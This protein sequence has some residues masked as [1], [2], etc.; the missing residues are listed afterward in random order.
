MPDEL[1]S[2]IVKPLFKKGS[3]LEVGNYR[4]VSLLCII[5]KVLERAIYVQL[6]DYLK[7]NQLFYE[8]QS[9]FRKSYSTDTCLI[10]LMDHI[11]Q[12]TFKGQYVGMVLLDL[13]KAFDTV[14]H[15]ILCNKLEA[16]GI[17][18]TKWFKSYLGDRKQIVVAN[19]TPSE[20]GTVSCG[21]P[22]GSILGPLLFLCYVN[23]MSLSVRCKLL[24]YADDSALIVSGTDP[25][26]IAD[27]LS[28]E[29][30][31][32]RQWLMDNKL[33][34]H[35]GKTESILFGSKRKL[36]KVESF[37]VKCGDITI[38]HVTSVKYLG[39]QIDND[40]GGNSI[41]KGI[42]SKVNSRVKFLYKYKDL[43]NFESR[44]TL[45]S[46]LI[47]CLFDYSC[48]S[49]YPG[50]NKDLKDKLQVAQ[51]KVIRFILNLDNRAH[52]G[53]QELETAGFLQVPDR[54]KQLKLG[55]V[56]RIKS[57]TCP[58]YLSANFQQLTEN[59]NG[60]TT[61][62]KAHNFYKPRMC[63]NTF[64][65]SAIDE[66]NSLPNNV[67]AIK[68]EKMFKESLKKTI[69]M[70]ARKSDESPFVYY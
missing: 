34:L 26:S 20:P 28:K 67:K 40:L 29:L 1:K 58:Q 32:C 56:F 2:A 15:E 47:Q 30:E 60:M 45:C 69:L 55:H 62:A 49:W 36:K 6:Y 9:G 31:S 35:L 54:V 22:Q 7:S 14:D 13:Q 4:P 37:D 42:I 44:K 61:R 3:R 65:Y 48:S 17:N 25:Q 43:L 51:N 27:E 16:M 38:K 63:T 50:I 19:G 10:N 46:A 66:W 21:V 57:K 52:I 11:R 68:N 8:F 59:D 53:N 5:S 12:L 33:S 39:V 64:A 41:V 23:D 70:D 24:L 18:N